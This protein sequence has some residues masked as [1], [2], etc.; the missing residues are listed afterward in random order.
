MAFDYSLELDMPLEVVGELKRKLTSAIRKALRRAVAWLRTES[1]KRLSQELGVKKTAL[2]NRFRIR[3]SRKGHS[4]RLWVGILPISAVK[5]GA[6]RQQEGGVKVRD[7][8]FRGAF[9][10]T[11]YGEFAIWKRLGASRHPLKKQTIDFS[12]E[13][14]RIIRQLEGQ[15]NRKFAQWIREALQ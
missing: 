11:V 12:S 4:A 6:A 2:K 14:E 7:Y 3:V 15:L 10:E 1:L 8:F 13:A 9:L 5:I